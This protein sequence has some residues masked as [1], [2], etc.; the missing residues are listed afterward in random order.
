MTRDKVAWNE[1]LLDLET[2]TNRYQSALQQIAQ[3]SDDSHELFHL[4]SIAKKALQQKA[5]QK[6]IKLNHE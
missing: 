4:K 5:T 2:V 1:L 3:A 6:V